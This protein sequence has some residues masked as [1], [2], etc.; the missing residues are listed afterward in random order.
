MDDLLRI[1]EIAL[2][3]I[4]N[5]IY[6]FYRKYALQ[7]ETNQMQ[8]D[9][10]TKQGVLFVFDKGKNKFS[11]TVQVMKRDEE[12]R[13]INQE[14]IKQIKAL[15][16]NIDKLSKE[17]SD[18]LP[19]VYFANHLYLPILLKSDKIDKISPAGLVESEVKFIRGLREYI[20]TKPDLLKDT[21]IYLLRNFPKSG[22]GFF[23]LS[24]YYPDFIMWLHYNK[25]Q[26]IVFLDPKGLQ[27]TKV[28]DDEKI[29]FCESGIKELEGKL[30]NI[31]NGNIELDSYIL[32]ITS[33]ANLIAKRTQPPTK[34]DYK[35]KHVLFLEDDDWAKQL[36]ERISFHS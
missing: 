30:K 1:E 26:K 29:V 7:Y 19:R 23:N 2:L 10:V 12:G 36:F 21:E 20:K 6:K 9:K 34:D 35:A 13:L 32:S 11:Y 8:Y 18:E 15:A 22:V 31:K 28:L 33:Y 24:G 25:K 5:Y 4:K 3:V 27:N 14:I 17:E 16:R